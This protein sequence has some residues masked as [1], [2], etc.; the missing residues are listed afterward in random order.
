ML[1][2]FSLKINLPIF[3]CFLEDVM[4]YLLLIIF[5]AFLPF[6]IFRSLGFPISSSIMFSCA[7]WLIAILFLFLGLGLVS[8][9]LL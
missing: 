3:L 1:C 7:F 9:G 4:F 5:L 2:F 6:T 8:K